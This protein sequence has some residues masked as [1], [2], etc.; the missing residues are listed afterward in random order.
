MRA[1]NLIPLFILLF[2]FSCKESD[3]ERITRLMVQWQG[4]EVQFPSKMIFTKFASD[5]VDYQIPQ[6]DYKIVVYVDSIG[7]TSCKLQL[8][9][10]KELIVT[11]DSVT[12]GSV[13]VL[14]FF[15]SNNVREIT[16]LLKRD[17]FDMPVCIN[18]NDEINKL[19]NFPSDLNFQTFL[20]DKNN[21]IKVIG[22]P[23]HNLSVR[24]LYLN[25]IIGEKTEIHNPV[26]TK[27]EVPV[28]EI[29]LGSFPENETKKANFIIMNIGNYPLLLKGTTSSCDCTTAE[30]DR[31]QVPP[32]GELK[33][34]IQYKPDKKG[35]FLRTVSV[36]IN[37][38]N[39]PIVLTITGSV[40]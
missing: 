39:S 3:K 29:D 19:N 4:K 16:Y 5:T 38:V 17:G 35:D 11:L 33:L 24:D 13:P 22:N 25:T 15:Q 34:T 31:Q 26:L 7:C 8:A 32:K 36:F 27:V 10:W 20:L 1:L 18:T 9:K 28:S 14:F 37:S 30:S 2:F 23:I 6:S 21:H 40:R 12:G